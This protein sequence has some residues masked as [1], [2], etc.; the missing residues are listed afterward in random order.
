MADL[1]DTVDRLARPLADDAGLDLVD[2]QVKGQGSRTKVQVIVDRKGGVDVGS[3]QQLSKALSRALDQEDPIAGRY[4]LE[5]TSPGTDHPLLD[6]RAFDRVE[7]R[8]V[9]AVLRADE[10]DT[11]REIIGTVTAA[12]DDAAELTADDGTVHRV[13]YADLVT[14]TQELRW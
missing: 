13:P 12:T 9:K 8:R 1:G 5:V 7:G 4:T 11:T 14:A 10:A 6:R 2:V 3:C